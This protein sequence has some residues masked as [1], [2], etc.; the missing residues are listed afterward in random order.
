M[1]SSLS[2]F[3][4]GSKKLKEHRLRL[5]ALVNNLNGENRMKGYPVALNMYSYVNL[6]DNQADYDDFIQNKSDIVIFIVEDKM[7]DKTREEF[8]LA[9]KAQKK[10]GSPKILVFMREFQERTP[11]IAEVEQLIS[12]NTDSYYIDYSNLEDLEYKVKERLTQ[13][14]E[15]RVAGTVASPKKKMRALKVWAL[16]ATLAAAFLFFKTMGSTDDATLLFIGGGSAVNCLEE[17]DGIGNLYQYDNSICIAVPT[18]TSWPIITS[19]VIHH[20]GIKNSGNSKPFYP[21]CLSAMSAEEADFLNMSNHDQFV[22]KGAVLALHL[23]EDS[24]TLYVKKTFTNSIID[25]RDSINTRELA[26]FLCDSTTQQLRIFTTEAGSGTL[27]FYQ[28]SLAPYGLTISKEAFGE[29][30]DKFTDLTPKSKIIS[31]ET[32]YIMLGSRYYVANEVYDEGDCRAIRIT[33]ENGV[34]I[35]KSIYLY[36]AGYYDD[37]GASFLIPAE[38]TDFLCKVNPKFKAII[39]N[40]RL[41]RKNEKVIVDLNE[42]LQ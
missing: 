16:L 42:Y 9:S 30:A 40:N 37:G 35:K 29:R 38:M 8:L 36:F 20:H 18:K 12:D 41:P 39:K 26:D 5:K 19:E 24:L 21:I 23:G 34:A 6:G 33:D 2:I 4:S 32:P 13:E 25:G 14:V 22:S 15:E 31:D 3:V 27:T 28:K 1:K 17:Y 10:K 11:E 7:G